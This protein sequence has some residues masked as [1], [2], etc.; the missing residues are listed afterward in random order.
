MITKTLF[1][2]VLVCAGLSTYLAAHYKKLYKQQLN[3]VVEVAV[4]NDTGDILVRINYD[5][6]ALFEGLCQVEKEYF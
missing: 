3:A 6:I 2:L 4:I 5:R 1:A